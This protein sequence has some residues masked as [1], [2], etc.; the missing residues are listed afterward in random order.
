[1]SSTRDAVLDVWSAPLCRLGPNTG[2]LR[3]LQRTPKAVQRIGQAVPRP[4][5]PTRGRQHLSLSPSPPAGEGRGKSARNRPPR[6]KV[7]FSLGGVCDFVGKS[8]AGRCG[9]FDNL[10]WM[11]FFIG[12]RGPDQRFAWVPVWSFIPWI[13]TSRSAKWTW[14]GTPISSRRSMK[15]SSRPPT[16][17]WLTGAV[18]CRPLPASSSTTGSWRRPRWDTRPPAPPP[19][20]PSTRTAAWARTQTPR[21][22]PSCPCRPGWM[23]WRTSATRASLW[24]TRRERV[25]T[26]SHQI[27]LLSMWKTSPSVNHH[28]QSHHAQVHRPHPTRNTRQLRTQAVAAI[29][30]V[31]W[32][33][34]RFLCQETM[35]FSN[36]AEYQSYQKSTSKLNQ[37]SLCLP[38]HHLQQPVTVREM[39]TIHPH[40][41]TVSR[42]K[43]VV[44]C[45]CLLLLVRQQ[46][47]QSRHHWSAANL[48]DPQAC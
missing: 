12:R 25:G 42:H 36:R 16:T 37:V 23:T 44:G 48:K 5:P 18:C 22:T 26:R 14:C 41:P 17:T 2:A 4:A 21:P 28:H 34:Q 47:N 31:Y 9:R 35:L 40:H 32:S 13:S 27:S 46:D 11:L 8:V 19:S 15:C 29:H 45:W 20:R 7:N 6:R 39:T 30:K 24:R 38:H 1:M 10:R 43:S 33:S 3:T